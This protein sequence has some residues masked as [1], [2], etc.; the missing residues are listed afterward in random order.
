MFSSYS[1]E[2]IEARYKAMQHGLINKQLEPFSVRDKSF[3][4]VEQAKKLLDP[5]FAKNLCHEPDGLIFQP[6]YDVRGRP[7]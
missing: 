7:I 6:A 2:L 3:W 4:E 5:K 1:F